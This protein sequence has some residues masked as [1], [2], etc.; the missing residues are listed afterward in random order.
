MMVGGV[1]VGSGVL[2]GGRGVGVSDAA[3][4]NEAVSVGRGVREG[5][6]VSLGT[7]V[8][9]GVEVGGSTAVA[10]SRASSGYSSSMAE[11]QSIPLFNTNSVKRAPG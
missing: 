3:K 7:G 10:V 6:E 9:E 5:P 4:V 11:R 8:I 2:V 1:E